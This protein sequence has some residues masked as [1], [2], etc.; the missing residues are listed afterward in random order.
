LGAYFRAI[1]H[2]TTEWVCFFNPDSRIAADRSL[3][4]LLQA[5]QREGVGAAGATTSLKS[6]L[7]NAVHAFR[8]PGNQSLLRRVLTLI[9]TT[10]DY[11]LFSISDSRSNAF[12]ARTPGRSPF[13]WNTIPLERLAG[14]RNFSD[15]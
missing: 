14:E 11:Q 13:K 7:R 4:K 3:R 15:S 2:V 8:I 9:H 12:V 1:G 6:G 5:A 10:T